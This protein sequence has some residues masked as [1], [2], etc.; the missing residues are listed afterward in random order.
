MLPTGESYGSMGEI[1]SSMDPGHPISMPGLESSTEKPVGKANS[2]SLN[3]TKSTFW[4]RSN[5]SY[6]FMMHC[7]IARNSQVTCIRHITLIQAISEW[8]LDMVN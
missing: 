1:L 5:V 2:S 6:H 8:I 4:G 3:A 7:L